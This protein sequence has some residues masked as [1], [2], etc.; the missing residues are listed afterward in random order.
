MQIITKIHRVG[1]GGGEARSFVVFILY[2]LGEAVIRLQ[3]R[4]PLYR[5]FAIQDLHHAVH[6]RM[7]V[8][9][10]LGLFPE[11]EHARGH[12]MVVRHLDVGDGRLAAARGRPRVQV[13]T[14]VQLIHVVV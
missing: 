8:Q 13:A 5:D 11:H 10:Y 1:R 7:V 9:R 6:E 14:G 2:L 12:E 4:V 3:S